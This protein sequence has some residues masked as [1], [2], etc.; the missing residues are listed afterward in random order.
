ML[1]ISSLLKQTRRLLQQ[2]CLLCAAPAGEQPVCAA[3]SKALPHHSANAC[4]QCA[5]PTHGGEVCGA[6]M[7]YPPDFDAT[8]A[9]F[10]YRFPID[11]LLHQL[12]YS[13]NLVLAE[14]AAENLLMALPEQKPDLLFAMPLH[15]SRLRERGF[16]QSVEIAK[17][18][19]WALNIPLKLEGY[20]KIRETEPQA[21]L[22]WKQRH[23]NVRGA[24]ACDL[25][26]KNK[27]IAVID[28]VMTTGSTLN[29]FA[30]TLK[31]RGAEKV[32]AWVVARTLKESQS[33]F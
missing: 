22:P 24:F 23:A 6:C 19:A 31:K 26:L 32:S 17:P 16:N 28:D 12:K 27:H 29:E 15:V 1:S 2:D 5:L 13:H 7:R 33:A 3:C 9:A 4:P 21:A 8:R 11:T 18:I 10:D 20:A 14:F 25:D 30:K